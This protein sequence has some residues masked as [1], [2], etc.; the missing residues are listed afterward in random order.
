MG[1]KQTFVRF[2]VMSALPPKA[3]IGTGT[4]SPRRISSGSLAMFAQICR[5]C[6]KKA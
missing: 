2:R 4:V 1:Q 6:P 5:A 3:D